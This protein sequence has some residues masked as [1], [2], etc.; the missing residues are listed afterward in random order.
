MAGWPLE[1]TRH[2]VYHQPQLGV[3]IKPLCFGNL[4]RPNPYNFSFLGGATR[5]W[6]IGLWNQIGIVSAT[7][8]LKLVDNTC[9]FCICDLALSIPDDFIVA[10]ATRL[11]PIG[12]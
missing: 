5:L 7:V 6:Q 4:W 11:W 10:V 2:C 12:L 9:L 1:S 3:H 8:K